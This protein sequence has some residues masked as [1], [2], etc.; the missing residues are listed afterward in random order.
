MMRK[1]QC[2]CYKDIQAANVL[3]WWDSQIAITASGILLYQKFVETG[4][5][6]LFGRG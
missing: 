6:H 2:M 4:E 3:R 1:R 5:I